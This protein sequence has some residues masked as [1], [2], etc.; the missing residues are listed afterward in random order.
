MH[1]HNHKKCLLCCKIWFFVEK[2]VSVNIYSYVLYPHI[3]GLSNISMNI[4][5]VKCN[6]VTVMF[7]SK[8]NF[9]CKLVAG[10][11]VCIS[12]F[13]CFN[14]ILCYLLLTNQLCATDWLVYLHKANG[15]SLT[16]LSLTGLMLRSLAKSSLLQQCVSDFIKWCS[17]S[18]YKRIKH[19]VWWFQWLVFKRE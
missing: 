1:N 10:K 12:G 13:S 16:H 7:P 19:E 3:C 17:S 5:N 4:F 9:C 2:N 8:R 6:L 11:P 18:D 14:H 15:E